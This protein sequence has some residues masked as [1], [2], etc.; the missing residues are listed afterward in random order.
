MYELQTSNKFFCKNN[1]NFNDNL[2]ILGSAQTDFEKKQWRSIQCMH[3]VRTLWYC[4]T[5]CTAQWCVRKRQR[6]PVRRGRRDAR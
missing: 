3:A 2:D 5:L 4:T 1:S 6:R